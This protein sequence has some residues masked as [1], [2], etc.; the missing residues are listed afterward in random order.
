M[1][2]Q[3]AQ[4]ARLV[5]N[6][7]IMIAYVDS[8]D[9]RYKDSF[10]EMVSKNI[11]EFNTLD[12]KFLEQKACA[13]SSY[14]DALYEAD[15]E[16][17]EYLLYVELGTVIDWC[18]GP[19]KDIVEYITQNSNSK[20]FGHILQHANGSYYIH[21]QFMAINVKW[22]LENNIR[23]IEEENPRIKWQ[24]PVFERS[25]EN[26]HD[27]YTPHWVKIKS[28]KQR[29][30]TRGQGKGWNIL[31]AI[32]E[33]NSEMKVW[34]EHIRNAKKFLYPTVKEECLKNKAVIF[35][36]MNTNRVYV[37]NTEE[38]TRDKYARILDNHD[39]KCIAT[40]ASGLS[41]FLL[42]FYAKAEKT[43]AYDINIMSLHFIEKCTEDWDGTNF[44]DFVL[45]EIV[46][47]DA[48][49][50]VYKAKGPH[51][52]SADK[53]LRQLGNE[54]L[55][56]WN[57]NGGKRVVTREI[58]IFNHHTWHNFKNHMLGDECTLLNI[59]NIMH[60]APTATLFNTQERID[61]LKNL[62]H[63]ITTKVMKPENLLFHGVSPTESNHPIVG[64]LQE[65]DIKSN[66]A[67]P[68][69]K[70]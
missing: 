27:E 54:W 7:K 18:D 57:Y 11:A 3:E 4:T 15:R 42:S 22:A 66:L 20:F 62:H 61:I 25:K 34:P 64:Y 70:I 8:H 30:K 33:T 68:W 24:A 17:C 45:S 46:N 50:A 40:P 23:K 49:N 60:Y 52:K 44:K 29:F 31:D 69:R 28:D 6:N 16:N 37:A 14:L 41:T 43:L 35:G 56:W 67:F 32:F 53:L 36:E 51:L 21:P 12:L 63:Y 9:N 26:F 39:V 2:T 38:I 10:I 19:M 47:H 59:S 65:R 13:K 48:L 5:R 1:I 58:D 55:D